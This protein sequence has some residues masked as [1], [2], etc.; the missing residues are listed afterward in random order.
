MNRLIK[1]VINFF[2]QPT[3]VESHLH[4]APTVSVKTTSPGS[5]NVPQLMSDLYSKGN[6]NYI[7][8]TRAHQPLVDIGVPE[9]MALKLHLILLTKQLSDS[10]S[11]SIPQAISDTVTRIKINGGNWCSEIT[12]IIRPDTKLFGGLIEGLIE[13]HMQLAV[14]RRLAL[15]TPDTLTAFKQMQT[16]KDDIKFFAD[17][18]EQYIKNKDQGVNSNWISWDTLDRVVVTQLLDT[19][20][21]DHSTIEFQSFIKEQQ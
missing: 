20:L 3:K 21:V 5:S 4:T 14:Y 8:P 10:Q 19:G 15:N 2:K 12:K 9:S 11:V 16:H 17:A 1:T 6:F 18:I 7:P 13:G